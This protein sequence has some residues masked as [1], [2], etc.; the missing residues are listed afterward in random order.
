MNNREETVKTTGQFIAHDKQGHNVVLN[1]I[2]TSFL[3]PEFATAMQEV[4]PIAC[5]AYTPVE[6]AFL[7]ANPQV[8]GV[9]DYYKPFEPLFKDGIEH[10]DW[11]AAERVMQDLLKTHFIFDTSKWAPEV[12]AM[13]ANDV[14]YVVTI[15]DQQ[16]NKLLGFRTLMQRANYPDGTLKGI[17][18]SIAQQYQQRGLATLLM[19]SIFRIIP[20]VKRTFMCTRVTNA[21][22]IKACA[23]WGFTK[24]EHPILDHAFN[25]EH[26][27]F[28]EYKADQVDTLQK[29]AAGF[30][31]VK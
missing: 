6:M 30:I 23:S 14:F 9:E 16:T 31:D 2:K 24:D 25:L 3:S 13:F 18:L 12:T 8:V 28:F 11:L 20:N 21:K 27:K 1:W 26:W 10:V 29:V 22:M 5:E 17:S 7:K 15:K 4:W 19:G